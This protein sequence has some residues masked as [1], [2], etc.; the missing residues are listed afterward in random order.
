MLTVFSLIRYP[1]QLALS[2]TGRPINSVHHAL[3]LNGIGCIVIRRQPLCDAP[4]HVLELQI[5]LVYARELLRG[6]AVSRVYLN[7]WV[8]AR[9]DRERAYDTAIAPGNLV[10]A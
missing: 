9:Q 5:V 6:F 7:D 4:R 2:G 3:L 1:Y 8:L 10:F